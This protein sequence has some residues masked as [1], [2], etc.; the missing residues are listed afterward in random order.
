VFYVVTW[1]EFWV[2]NEMQDDMYMVYWKCWVRYKRE[3]VA[4][5]EVLVKL[6]FQNVK[7]KMNH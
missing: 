1:V 4:I 5:F 2:E 6:L 3:I 7:W